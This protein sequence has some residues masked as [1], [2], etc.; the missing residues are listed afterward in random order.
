MFS[1]CKLNVYVIKRI[2][3]LFWAL[4]TVQIKFVISSL[5]M[6]IVAL[7]NIQKEKDDCNSLVTTILI[8]LCIFVDEMRRQ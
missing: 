3:I 7:K 1:S 5:D 4:S 6:N 8:I 2:K